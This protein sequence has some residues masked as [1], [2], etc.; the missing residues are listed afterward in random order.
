LQ[1]LASGFRAAPHCAHN[2]WSLAPQFSQNS[3]S[4]S[5]SKEQFV[6]RMTPHYPHAWIL[7]SAEAHGVEFAQSNSAPDDLARL[8]TGSHQKIYPMI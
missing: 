2:L 5:F 4:G 7:F 1:N 8:A 6:Q 3:A